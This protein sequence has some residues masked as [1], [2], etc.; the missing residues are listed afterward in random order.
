L[1]FGR[2][3]DQNKDLADE[4]KKLKRNVEKI[5]K[6]RDDLEDQNLFLDWKIKKSHEKPTKLTT[7]TDQGCPHLQ[8]LCQV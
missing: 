4:N 5:S 8:V 1:C 7:S 2:L 3:E 6:E